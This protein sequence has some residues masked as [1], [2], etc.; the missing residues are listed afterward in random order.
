MSSIDKVRKEFM[1][2]SFTRYRQKVKTSGKIY[3]K[4]NRRQNKIQRYNEQ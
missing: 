2:F 4:K 1:T 3:G